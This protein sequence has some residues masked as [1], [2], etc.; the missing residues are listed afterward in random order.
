MGSDLN[1][2]FVTF[3]IFKDG[4]QVHEMLCP[5]S[6]IQTMTTTWKYPGSE[7]VVHIIDHTENFRLNTDILNGMVRDRIR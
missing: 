4:E 7:Y 2:F 6:M 1:K 3:R 5:R